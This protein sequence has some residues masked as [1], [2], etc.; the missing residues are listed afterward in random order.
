MRYEQFKA[1]LLEKHEGKN[2]GIPIST[3]L[4]QLRKILTSFAPGESILLCG[5]TGV[6]K[7]R[8]TVK[9]VIIDS[10]KSMIEN[11]NGMK[12]RVLYNTLEI[13]SM[14]IYLMVCSYLFKTKLKKYYSREQ[15]L[16]LLGDKQVNTEFFEDLE[17]IR[18]SLEFLS[19]WVTIVE[20]CRTPT[21]WFKYCEKVLLDLGTV[22]NGKYVKKNPNIHVIIVTDTLN[23]FTSEKNETKLIGMT[24][25]SSDYNKMFLRNF[26]QCTTVTLQQLSKDSQTQMW[27][28]TGKKVEEKL[29]PTSENLKDY[30]SS[31]DDSSTVLAIFAPA[32]HGLKKWEGYDV[33]LFGN[34]LLF[35]YSLKAN[36]SELIKPIPLYAELGWLHFEE[37]P[38]NYKEPTLY[39]AF[40]KQHNLITTGVNLLQSPAKLQFEQLFNKENGTI[41]LE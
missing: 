15:M 10:L 39:E 14:E 22:V 29:V 25:F 5:G 24:K 40:L 31:P 17:K 37:I 28:N 23:S 18:P 21:A 9:H 11:P 26:Y 12:V 33:E 32:R 41:E 27:S 13:S 38:D 4:P 1:T 8:W 3:K 6:S 20:D 30:R 35:L 19:T 7:S 36:F 2:Q 16:N 34:K